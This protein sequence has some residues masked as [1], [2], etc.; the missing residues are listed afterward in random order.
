M[1]VNN[2]FATHDKQQLTP[3]FGG[4]LLYTPIIFIF[5]YVLNFNYIS[6]YDYFISY[7][8]TNKI[9]YA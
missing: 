8:I 7:T 3:L 1:E 2:D 5:D 4:F 6:I 9:Y